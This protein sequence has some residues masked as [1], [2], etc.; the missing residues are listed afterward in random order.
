MRRAG[1]IAIGLASAL[2]VSALALSATAAAAPSASRQPASGPAASRQ[3]NPPPRSATPPPRSATMPDDPATETSHIVKAGETLGGIAARAQ[4]PRILIIEANGLTA[5]YGVR[6]GQVLVIPRRRTHV[7]KPGETGFAIAMDYG[8]PWSKIATA[9]G[10][11]PKAR[12]RAGQKLAIPILTKATPPPPLAPG[13]RDEDEDDTLGPRIAGAPVR[14]AWPAA[15]KVRRG[16]VPRAKGASSRELGQNSG[17]T[18]P[19][20]GIDITGAKGDPVRAAAPGLVWY[21]GKEPNLY[22]NVV[23]IDHGSGWFSAYAKLLKVTV[24][25]G[26]PVRAGERVGLIGNTGSTPTTELH[27][28]VRR[29]T[30][31]VDP[32][33]LLPQRN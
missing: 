3:A 13:A 6:A 10:L 16:F 17:K 11:D 32:L 7:T 25:K 30:V 26:D 5:P 29:K 9:N 20:D 12:V 22:G 23:I 8:V 31:P 27:F 15:G 28:E 1:A 21:A 4:V 33:K 2:S 14:F 19:H 18:S 24:K